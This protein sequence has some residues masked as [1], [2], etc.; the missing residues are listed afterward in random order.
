MRSWG[1][2]MAADAL[3][4]MAGLP[5]AVRGALEARVV[6]VALL[7]TGDEAEARAIGELSDRAEEVQVSHQLLQQRHRRVDLGANGDEAAGDER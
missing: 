2:V 7:D 1:S 4:L 6:E 5:E 3:T